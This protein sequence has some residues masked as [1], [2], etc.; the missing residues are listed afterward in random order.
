MDTWLIFELLGSLFPCFSDRCGMIFTKSR[1]MPCSCVTA[2]EK[3]SVLCELLLC[4]PW[5]PFKPMSVSG[6]MPDFW[7][8]WNFQGEHN[9]AFNSPLSRRQLQKNNVELVQSAVLQL[10]QQ[11]SVLVAGDASALTA[12]PTCPVCPGRATFVNPSGLGT[13]GCNHRG[14]DCHRLSVVCSGLISPSSQALPDGHLKKKLLLVRIHWICLVPAICSSASSAGS[15]RA[16]FVLAPSLRSHPNPFQVQVLVLQ[17]I[18]S[19][20]LVSWD[21]SAPPWLT[22][23]M[24]QDQ[25]VSFLM[26]PKGLSLSLH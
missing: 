23:C 24:A 12:L 3:G 14:R 11:Q 16:R 25:G 6:L 22:A 10:C 1:G 20:L 21:R 17:S 7:H 15:T 18:L 8:P 26:D 19:V 4:W 9:N 13:Q 5:E 2:R